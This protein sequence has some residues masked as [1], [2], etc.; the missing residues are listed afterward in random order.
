MAEKRFINANDIRFNVPYERIFDEV[1]IDIEDVKKAI[2][3]TP[4]ADVEE[5]RHG[6]WYPDYETFVD[7]YDR[8]SAPVQTGWYCSVCGRQESRREPYCHCGAKMDG[9]RR[10]Q[11]NE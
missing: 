4:T 3:Q 5:V 2:A 6:E 1:F 11:E 8:E 10:D 9:R 7:E